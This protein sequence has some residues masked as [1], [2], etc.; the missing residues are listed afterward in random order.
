MFRNH[1]WGA[2]ISLRIAADDSQFGRATCVKVLPK[3]AMVTWQRIKGHKSKATR[4]SV[5]KQYLER[6]RGEWREVNYL[7]LKKSVWGADEEYTFESR[8]TEMLHSEKVKEPLLVLHFKCHCDSVVSWWWSYWRWLCTNR[9]VVSVMSNRLRKEYW[10]F[11]KLESPFIS[12]TATCFFKR[13]SAVSTRYSTSLFKCW[14]FFLVQE[15]SYQMQH[16]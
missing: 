7:L 2:R 11:L 6:D 9:G 16:W 15:I 14:Y 4:P 10:M 3:T 13:F 1:V 8:A 5:A 12:A